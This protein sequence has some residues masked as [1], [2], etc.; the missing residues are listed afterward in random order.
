MSQQTE[1]KTGDKSLLTYFNLSSHYERKARL[2]PGLLCLMTLIPVGAA[3]GTSLGSWLALAA[4]GLGLWAV[5]GV[6]LSHLSSA[7]GNRFQEK[8]WPRWPYDAPTHLWLNPEDRTASTQQKRLMNEAIKRLTK[9]DLEAAVEQG[10]KEV[11]AV[12]NDCITRLRHRL[13]NS[14]H[15]DRLDVH[16]ADYG[17]ARNLAGLRP[18]W[19]TF[20]LLSTVGCWVGYARFGC[21]FVWCASSSILLLVGVLVSLAIERYVRVRARHYTDSL[22]SAVQELDATEHKTEPLAAEPPK[23]KRAAKKR[24]NEPETT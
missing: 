23:A 5:C 16:N 4:T 7:A 21:S 6:G 22:F 1:K 2:L 9:L 11:D 18:L 20:L 24:A 17:F 8:V 15:G 3:F 14:P 10:P 13:R 19:L 12:L